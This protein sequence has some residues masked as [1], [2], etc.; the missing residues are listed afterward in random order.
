MSIVLVAKLLQLVAE[1]YVKWVK[2]MHSK[3][4]Q[5]YDAGVRHDHECTL[6]YKLS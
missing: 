2:G 5:F 3:V 6:P 4:R 1:L